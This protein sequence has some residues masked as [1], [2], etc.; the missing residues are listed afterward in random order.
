MSGHPLLCKGSRLFWRLYLN[1]LLMVIAIIVSF[2]FLINLA[3]DSSHIPHSIEKYF[4]TDLN[5]SDLDQIALQERLNRL[6]N[7]F[8]VNVGVFGTDGELIMSAGPEPPTALSEKN[9]ITLSEP[10]RKFGQSALPLTILKFREPGKQ[11]GNYVLIQWHLGK[12]WKYFLIGAMVVLVVC[13]LVLLP[14]ARTISSPLEHI[15]RVTQLFGRGDLTARVKLKR[16]DE[17]G[18]LANAFDDMATRIQKLIRSEKELLAN[19]SHEFRTP[20]SRIRVA[21][22]LCDEESTTTTELKDF[23]SGIN[24]DITELDNLVGSVLTAARL[25]MAQ[26]D[27]TRSGFIPKLETTDLAIITQTSVN[28]FSKTHPQFQVTIKTPDKPALISIDPNLIKRV[29][30]NLLDNAGKYAIPSH[31][32]T[33]CVHVALSKNSDTLILVVK[34]NGPGV[35]DKILPRLFEPFFQA[36][37][38]RPGTGVGLAL[39]RTIAEVHQGTLTAKK[40]S[41]GGLGFCLTL[42]LIPPENK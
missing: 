37:K 3:A 38:T 18:V 13:A 4:L 36:D 42:P 9:A 30:D 31:G 24:D 28:Y 35:S 14:L 15:S 2:G 41:A 33:P 26:D 7:I 39:C 25:D 6:H 10:Y 23:L 34:D 32:E 1:G 16:K 5:D 40:R 20:L 11:L 21:L 17:I 19:V 27:E 8:G 22:E 29:I 12:K